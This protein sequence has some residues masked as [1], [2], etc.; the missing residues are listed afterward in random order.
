MVKIA[1]LQYKFNKNDKYLTPAYAV[2]SII[3][4]LKPDNTI[5]CPFDREGMKIIKMR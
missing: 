3:K 5:W 2:Y 1:Q 4:Y